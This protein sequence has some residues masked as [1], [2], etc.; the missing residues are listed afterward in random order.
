[1]WQQSSPMRICWWYLLQV[2]NKFLRGPD[3]CWAIDL[4]PSLE[5]SAGESLVTW[6]AGPF[7]SPVLHCFAPFKYRFTENPWWLCMS[8]FDAFWIYAWPMHFGVA[9]LCFGPWFRDDCSH[10]FSWLSLLRSNVSSIYVYICLYLYIKHQDIPGAQMTCGVA[11]LAN[12]NGGQ[13]PKS[14]ARF[15]RSTVPKYLGDLFLILP[16]ASGYHPQ[17]LHA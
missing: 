10:P 1:M 13:A 2:H 6:I 7:V 4:F 11:S 14:R 17:M 9:L 16:V 12:A 15:P 5:S 3:L 8:Y